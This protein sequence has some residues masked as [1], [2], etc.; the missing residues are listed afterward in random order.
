[1]Y[2]FKFLQILKWFSVI[3]LTYLVTMS[4]VFGIFGTTEIIQLSAIFAIMFGDL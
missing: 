3:G 1:M 2:K 4:T